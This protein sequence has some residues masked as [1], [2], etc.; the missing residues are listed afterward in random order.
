MPLRL[1]RV[2]A[3]GV[4]LRDR[5]TAERW[6]IGT[7]T[8]CIVAVVAEWRADWLAVVAVAAERP[9]RVLCDPSAA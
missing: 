9:G 3:T 5:P 2:S 1:R 8:V 6:H 4:R 7:E